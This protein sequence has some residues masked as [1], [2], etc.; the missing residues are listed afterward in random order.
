MT[1]R[2]G[3]IFLLYK[4]SCFSKDYTSPQDSISREQDAL[5]R[6]ILAKEVENMLPHIIKNNTGSKLMR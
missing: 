2:Q 4:C 3:T 1:I 5:Q 6:E